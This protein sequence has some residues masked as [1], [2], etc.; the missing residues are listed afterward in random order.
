MKGIKQIAMGIRNIRD[1]LPN[2]FR[3]QIAEAI[4]MVGVR[5]LQ[6]MA[7]VSLV[8]EFGFNPGKLALV[9]LAYALVSPFSTVVLYLM[10][11]LCSGP[12]AKL[13]LLKVGASYVLLSILLGLSVCLAL[14]RA[15]LFLLIPAPEHFRLALRCTA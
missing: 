4:M 9:V 14:T 3:L 7:A 1:S 2:V 8:V 13:T 15:L 12:Q 10:V 11:W 5:T 6:I